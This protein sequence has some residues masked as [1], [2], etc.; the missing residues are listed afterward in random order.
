M[1]GLIPYLIHAMKKQRPQQSYRSF[2]VGSSRSYQLLNGGESFE[3]SS[4]RRTRSD[5]QP[6]IMDLV[7]QRSGIEYMH[8]GNVNRGALNPSSLATGSGSYPQQMNKE[9]NINF[10]NLRR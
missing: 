2:S 4:H 5:F 10:S 8:S 6:S 7:E 1:E 9:A 3:G